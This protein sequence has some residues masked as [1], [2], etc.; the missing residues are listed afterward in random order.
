M[1]SGPKTNPKFSYEKN[2]NNKYKQLRYAC[3]INLKLVCKYYNW[4]YLTVLSN[5]LFIPN[6][7]S[8]DAWIFFYILIRLPCS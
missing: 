3:Q 2:Y 7:N 1:E 5:F 4:W 6:I 8:L